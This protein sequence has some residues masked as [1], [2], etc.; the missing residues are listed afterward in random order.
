MAD[1][2]R[3]GY[4]R[5]GRT[6]FNA[7]SV[8]P[9]SGR[10]AGHT[11]GHPFLPWTL[12][13]ATVRLCL[14]SDREELLRRATRALSR[15]LVADHAEARG[16]FQWRQSAVAALALADRLTEGIRKRLAMCQ[17]TQQQ[18]LRS[19]RMVDA[20]RFSVCPTNNNRLF[21]F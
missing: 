17:A 2:I 21:D 15:A 3:E 8:A 16:Y 19:L 13:V 5:L 7:L 9:L 6:D 10:A 20:W 18:S 11:P 12:F 1:V 14:R 4:E